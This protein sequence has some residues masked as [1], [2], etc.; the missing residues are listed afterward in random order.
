MAA[1]K[2][3]SKYSLGGAAYDYSTKY[4]AWR[5]LAVTGRDT[6]EAG[7]E[8]SVFVGLMLASGGYSHGMPYP[9]SRSN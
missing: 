3:S 8:H 2:T 9:Y 1:K 6:Y 5:T 7:R 4:N